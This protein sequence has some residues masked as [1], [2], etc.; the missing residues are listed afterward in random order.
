MQVF[1]VSRCWR[2]FGQQHWRVLAILLPAL[3]LS[4]GC[5]R[6]QPA[7]YVIS[8]KIDELPAKQRAP[9]VDVLKRYFGTPESPRLMA[10]S[11]AS[12][13]TLLIEKADPAHLKLGGRIYRRRCASCH[14]VTGD[15]NGPAAEYLN[16]PPRNYLPGKFKFMS[17]PRGSK[18]RRLD[19]IRTIRFGAKGTSMPSFRWLPDDEMEAVVDYVILLSRR[20]ELEI[21][22][23]MEAEL[24]L[25][26]EDDF[27]LEVVGDIVNDIADSWAEAKH[28]VVLPVVRRPASSEETVMLGRK[29]F[30]TKG[31]AKCH[32][33]DG[34]GRPE[35]VGKDDW[36]HLAFA[37]DIT[38]GT[39]HGGRRPLDIYRRI[40]AGINGTPMPGFSEALKDE[41]ETIWHLVDYVRAVA[42]GQEFDPAD[43]E[44]YRPETEPAETEPAETE[45]AETEPA[46]DATQ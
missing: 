42:A 10:P 27:D 45:P 4:G 3:L 40:Y 28:Q 15:G 26:E 20:G 30:L 31:C 44:R 29:A 18:P 5:T 43:I 1:T 7:V 24:E 2:P 6:S 36:G 41:P 25:D 37:A 39:L 13:G 23:A 46:A 8:A 19:L 11:V 16:P 9:A 17:T 34:R 35:N 12:G 33:A 21:Q 38:M 22:L 32:G 14:G